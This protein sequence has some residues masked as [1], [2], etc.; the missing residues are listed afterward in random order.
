MTQNKKTLVRKTTRIN[1]YLAEKNIA[2]RREA[3]GMI[4]SGLVFI[5]GKRAEL[6]AQI[7]PKDTVT[8]SKQNQKQ[9]VYYA[10]N[11]PTGIVT[12]GAQN[13]EKEIRHITKFPER[14]YPVGRLDKE[15][16]GLLILTND[17]RIVKKL[18]DPK[19]T[20]EKEY[21]VKVDKLVTD[22]FI[23]KMSEGIILDGYKT[24]KAIVKKIHENAFNI[25]LTEGKNRQI[26]RMCQTLGYRV[27]DLQRIRIMNI[28]LGSLKPGTYRKIKVAI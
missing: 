8:V 17:G 24:K 26:R 9:Y 20:H 12:I 15:S 11:K 2:S 3:D 21:I 4:R 18:L 25:I 28:K 5:N 7:G 10:Y 6:G 13:K 27:L 23:K 16:H 14:V 19:Y 1:A 22:S